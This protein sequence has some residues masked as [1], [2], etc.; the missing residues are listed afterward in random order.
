MNPIIPSEVFEWYF[1]DKFDENKV[2]GPVSERDLDVMWKTSL[3]NSQTFVWKTGIPEWKALHEIDDLR[4]KIAESNIETIRDH[5]YDK[6]IT[7]PKKPNLHKEEKISEEPE[8]LESKLEKIAKAKPYKGGDGLWHYMDPTTKEM[9]TSEEDPSEVLVDDDML[10]ELVHRLEQEGEEE[11]KDGKKSFGKEGE[12]KKKKRPHGHDLD[13]EDLTDEQRKKIEKGRKKAKKAAEKKKQKWYQPKINSNIYARGLPEDITH[14]DMKEFF[15][16]AGILRLDPVSGEERIKIYRDEKGRPK[17]DALI[18]YAKPESVDIALEML[19]EREIKPRQK[20]LLERANFEQ[21]G[22]YVPRKLVKVDEVTKI[23]LK[24]DQERQ[25]SW[26]DEEAGEG[27]KIVVIK[28]MFT[29]EEAEAEETFFEDL[30]RDILEECEAKLGP[31]HRI[32][33]FENHPQGV[34]QIK[35]KEAAAAEGCIKLMEGRF[36]A[37]RRIECFYWDGVTDYRHFRENPDDEQKRIDEFGEWLEK[38]ADK[39]I[40]KVAD[41]VQ[42]EQPET[43]NHVQ[44]GEKEGVV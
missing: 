16:R 12:K 14:D 22:D 38:E 19:N 23:K 29:L 30:K 2:K 31:V 4:K 9:R 3:I 40:Q 5:V 25:F 39:E 7:A 17:G 8:T 37:G 42:A 34:V 35:F 20:I 33:I 18:S 26:A 44:Q 1:L 36:F 6:S 43:D 15:S 10:E 41:T 27:L 21:K 32:T 13:M 24:S 28:N 11:N